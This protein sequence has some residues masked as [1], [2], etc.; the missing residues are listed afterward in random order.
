MLQMMDDIECLKWVKGHD[1]QA[2]QFECK[3]IGTKCKQTIKLC[4]QTGHVCKQIPLNCKQILQSG[5]YN[6]KSEKT[7]YPN[8]CLIQVLGY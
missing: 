1:L 5:K 7:E 3:Q 4:K 2:N 6:L 8:D